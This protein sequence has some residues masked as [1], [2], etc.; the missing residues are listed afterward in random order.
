MRRFAAQPGASNR[1]IADAAEV[2]D[3]GQIS[4]VLARLRNLGL[5]H[6]PGQWRVGESHSWR[7]T[8]RARRTD[9]TTRQAERVI[10]QSLGEDPDAPAPS[11]LMVRGIVA[12]GAHV[13]RARLLN[14]HAAELAGELWDLCSAAAAPPRGRLTATGRADP[15]RVGGCGPR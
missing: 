13:V 8:A 11:P 2:A 3:Q 6:G 4:K 1:E 9:R 15:R 12:D 7:L 5:I 10:S 14:D